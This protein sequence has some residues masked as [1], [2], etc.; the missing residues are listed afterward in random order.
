ME[1]L[2]SA[3]SCRIQ[4]DSSVTTSTLAALPTSNGVA[5]AT[6][7][8]A[9][10]LRSLE[11]EQHQIN[12]P[13]VAPEEVTASLTPVS[14]LPVGGIA[15]EKSNLPSDTAAFPTTSVLASLSVWILTYL[16]KFRGRPNALRPPMGP[17]RE[18]AC[19]ALFI[20]LGFA[21]VAVLHYDVLEDIDLV[22][23]VASLGATTVML[24]AAV[25]SPLAQPRNV[26]AGHVVSAVIGISVRKLSNFV[27][28]DPLPMKW[29]FGT[30]AITLS[31]F[32]MMCTNTVHPPGG[33]T[34]LI[35]VLGGAKVQRLGYLFVV[36]PVLTA[37]LTMLAL[38]VVLNN[39]V[40]GRQYPEFWW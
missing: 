37:L 25:S 35:A 6:E 14:F 26:I 9:A 16:T 39:L 11:V 21:V 18:Q 7:S 5:M 10:V 28:G 4:N 23:V 30:L 20:L 8:S 36:T 13:A 15:Q 31:V 19:S 38:A 34:A 3:S 24:F 22:G 1:G 32:V 27:F 2:N 40:E 33:A 12:D 17:W 29:P